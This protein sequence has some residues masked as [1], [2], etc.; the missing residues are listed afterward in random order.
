[1]NSTIK[2]LN[3]LAKRVKI[4]NQYGAKL[5]YNEQDDWQR[6]STGWHC[7]L[8]Y[9]GRQYSFDFWQGSAITGE[10]DAAGTLDCLLSDAQS[11]EMEFSEFCREFGYDEDSRKSEKT[12]KAC[13]KTS[14]AMKRLL[15]DDYD[16]FVYADRN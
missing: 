2:S 15:G 7:T 12:W 3:S 8:R 9:Q 1:M 5:D 10:P 13:Q 4:I 16:E 6:K 14:T 11:G